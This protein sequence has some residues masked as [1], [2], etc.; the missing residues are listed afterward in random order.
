M[1]TLGWLLVLCF[2]LTGMSCATKKQPDPKL[3]NI[4]KPDTRVLAV[5]VVEQTDAGFRVV[6]TV[7][8][9]NENR[10]ALP[11][12]ETRY[13]IT[14]GQAGTLSLVQPAGRTLPAHGKQTLTLPAS[15]AWN[16]PAPAGAP[17]TVKG[18]VS[19]RPP[20]ELRQVMTET[21]IPLP[22]ADFQEQG[23][24]N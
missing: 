17:W 23:Q 21:N 2:A 20:G 24:L 3:W 19:Y 12:V 4:I 22:W 11:L 16:G 10:V 13:E 7:E 8:L 6:A 5:D 18:R 1:K 15:F 14:V 9:T